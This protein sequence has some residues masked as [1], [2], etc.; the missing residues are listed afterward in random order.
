MDNDDSYLYEYHIVDNT[1]QTQQ[2]I[3]PLHQYHVV[4]STPQA[5]QDVTP[6]YQYHVVDSTPQVVTPSYSTVLSD[7]THEIV[8]IT[9]PADTSMFSPKLTLMRLKRPDFII[10]YISLLILAILLIVIVYFGERTP[11]NQGL[12]RPNINPWFVRILWIV[13]TIFS[14]AAYYFIWESIETHDI[15]KDLI[16]S[17]LYIVSGFLFVGWAVAY[18]YAEDITLSLWIA[19]LIFIYN[20]WLFIYVWYIRPIA[21]LF[22]IPNLILYIYLLYTTIHIASLNNIPI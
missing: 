4:D 12:I 18:Y 14:Y 22:L 2:D 5:Q 7:N 17:V 20:L 9:G 10:V 6:L 11:W 21:A 1:H 8:G 19:V 16:V 13:G 3:T 15:P